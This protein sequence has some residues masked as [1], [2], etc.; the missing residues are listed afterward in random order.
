MPHDRDGRDGLLFRGRLKS[1]VIESVDPVR[2]NN[3]IAQ[4]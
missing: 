2:H 1:V 4:A 3:S